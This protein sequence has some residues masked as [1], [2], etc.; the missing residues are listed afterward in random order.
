M[1]WKAKTTHNTF[2]NFKQFLI[3][4]NRVVR[5]QD[6]HKKTEATDVGF[7]S[8]SSAQEI[9]DRLTDKMAMAFKELAVATEETINLAFGTKPK[10]PAIK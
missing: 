7:H 8:A 9:E 4:R 2:A 6:K 10:P 1:E 5:N 3:D